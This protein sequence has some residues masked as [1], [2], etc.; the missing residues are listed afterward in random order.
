MR[1][2]VTVGAILTVMGV[3]AVAHAQAQF[4]TPETVGKDNVPVP[5]QDRAF[6]PVNQRVPVEH[7]ALVEP[8]LRHVGAVP[9]ASFPGSAVPAVTL[10]LPVLRP[11]P[12]GRWILAL[13]LANNS[14]HYADVRAI[15]AF[16]NAD[17][18]VGEVNVLMRGVRPG[19][20][21]ATEIAGPPV[22]AFVDNAGC[23]VL[24]PLQ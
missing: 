8:P 21:V 23:Q 16:R 14:P 24:S 11:Q 1:R 6:D 22:I 18:P 10:G 4:Y 7:V 2:L 13:Q 20:V 19:D 9:I 12:G 5:P 15:C 17:R 3:A